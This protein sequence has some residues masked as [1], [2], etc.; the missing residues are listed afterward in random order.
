VTGN[1]LSLVAPAE[2]EGD[3]R[4]DPSIDQ[5]SITPDGSSCSES[6]PSSS[7]SSSSSDEE[8]PSSSS[9]S[10]SSSDDEDGSEDEEPEDQTIVLPLFRPGPLPTPTR[11]PC[12]NPFPWGNDYVHD[13]TYNGI[14]CRHQQAYQDDQNPYR[15]EYN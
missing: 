8:E 11:N 2:I 7:S 4:D 5:E 14:Y 3:G 12:A 10:S 9:N 15:F 13:H 6:N 1:Q